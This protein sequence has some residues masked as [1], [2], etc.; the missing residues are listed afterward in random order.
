[1]TIPKFTDISKT[2]LFAFFGVA[3]LIT[4][5][6]VFGDKGLLDT[7][8]ISKDR[9][10]IVAYNASLEEKNRVLEQEIALL[11]DDKRY[12]ASIARKQLGMIGSDEIIYKFE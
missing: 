3:L 10:G 2:H 1:M 12:I 8:N 7:Y 6:T 5:Y 4:V 9:D 11:K